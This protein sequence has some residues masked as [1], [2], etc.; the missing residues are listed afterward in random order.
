MVLLIRTSAIPAPGAGRPYLPSVIAALEISS[1]LRHFTH[2]SVTAM[3]AILVTL[4]L[5]AYWI[6]KT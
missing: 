6:L 4:A 3:V 1:K 2:D 5:L